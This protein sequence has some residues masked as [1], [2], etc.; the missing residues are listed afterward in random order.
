MHVFRTLRSSQTCCEVFRRKY[1]EAGV[2]AVSHTSGQN[3]PRGVFHCVESLQRAL[4]VVD[5]RLAHLHHVHGTCTRTITL[6]RQGKSGQDTAR[7]GVGRGTVSLQ[8]TV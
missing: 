5:Q 2:P 6:Q 4:S 3:S 1:L 7:A 8:H